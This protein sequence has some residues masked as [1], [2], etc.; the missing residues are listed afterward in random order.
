MLSIEMVA[1][2]GMPVGKSV[3]ETCVWIGRFMEAFKG[4]KIYRTTFPEIKLHFCHSPRAKESA[5]KYAII[6]TFGG[7]D[8]AIGGKKCRKCKGKGWFGAGRKECP[9]CAGRKWEQEPGLFANIRGPHAWAALAVAL[10]IEDF[11]GKG[12][13]VYSCSKGR[14]DSLV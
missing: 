5:V 9:E 14:K 6:D 10:Y 8:I 12:L 3:F 1:S 13:R 11:Y 2:Y 4:D 7:K